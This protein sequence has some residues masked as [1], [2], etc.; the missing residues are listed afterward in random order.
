M[1]ESAYAHTKKDVVITLSDNGGAHTYTPSKEVGDLSVSVGG[2]ATI[3]MLDRGEHMKPRRGDAQNITISFTAH[4]KDVGNT[5][6]ATLVDC[7]EPFKNYVDSNWTSVLTGVSDVDAV[8]FAYTMDGTWK[9]EADKTLT[10]E[11]MV[12]HYSRADGDPNS[13]S[14]S[15]EAAQTGMTL[16]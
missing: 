5:T 11:D 13:V 16:L 9:G 6:A 12:L 10:T 15:G 1:A 2:Y 4:E 3:W 14:I 7:C 8:D